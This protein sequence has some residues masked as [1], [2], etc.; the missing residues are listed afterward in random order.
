MNMIPIDPSSVAF[1]DALVRSET[2]LWRRVEKELRVADQISLVELTTSRAILAAGPNARVKDLVSLL[3]ITVGTASKAVD[4]LEN[5]G[6]AVRSPAADDRRSSLITLTD[7]GLVMVADG[8]AAVRRAMAPIIEAVDFDVATVTASLQ[9]L[10]EH[11]SD[12]ASG[13]VR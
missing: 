8:E 7:R 3:G 5:A 13:A 11:T 4:R 12:R 10:L 2:F 6:L 9:D 1:F